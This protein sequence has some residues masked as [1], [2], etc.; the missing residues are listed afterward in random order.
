ME[1]VPRLLKM[2]MLLRLMVEEDSSSNAWVGKGTVGR[3]EVTGADMMQVAVYR[4]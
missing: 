3:V 1:S 4:K 2:D